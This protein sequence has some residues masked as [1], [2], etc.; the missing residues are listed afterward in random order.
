[1]EPPSMY[2]ASAIWIAV[3]NPKG[4]GNSFKEKTAFRTV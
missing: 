3:V 4:Q 2:P 1:M